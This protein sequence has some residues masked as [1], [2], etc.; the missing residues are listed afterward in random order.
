MRAQIEE[1][2]K[3]ALCV[4]RDELELGGVTFLGG[5]GFA[6]ASPLSQLTFAVN[7][8]ASPPSHIR[9]E[10]SPSESVSSVLV[11]LNVLVRGDGFQVELL[12]VLRQASSR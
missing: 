12:K 2:A 9:V 11:D 10:L 6:R 8:D 1:S 3:T 5:P 7:G 4:V